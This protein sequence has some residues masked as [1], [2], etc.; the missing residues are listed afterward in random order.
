M[1]VLPLCASSASSSS[2]QSAP[3]WETSGQIVV[4]EECLR[5]TIERSMKQPGHGS[6]ARPDIDTMTSAELLRY[7][8]QTLLDSNQYPPEKKRRLTA[9]TGIGKNFLL[10]Q[11]VKDP[12]KVITPSP[13]EW[14][15]KRKLNG[16]VAHVTAA[17]F[18]LRVV[19]ARK[20]IKELWLHITPEELQNWRQ[21]ELTFGLPSLTAEKGGNFLEDSIEMYGGLFTWHSL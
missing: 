20:V 6:V 13:I 4:T 1:A 16:F 5:T 8:A 2:S 10:K 9:K 21:V 19:A 15:C 17:H 18:G 7:H 11:L 14:A 3:S 12:T